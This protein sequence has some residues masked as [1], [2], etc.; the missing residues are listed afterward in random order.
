MDVLI[1]VLVVLV[2]GISVPLIMK[3]VMKAQK[4]WK[5]KLFLDNGRMD[6]IDEIS[7]SINSKKKKD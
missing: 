5:R 7:A 3:G 4:K 6:I 2:V 1:C